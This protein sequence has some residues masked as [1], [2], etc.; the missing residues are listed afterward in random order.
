[1]Q[2]ESEMELKF[3]SLISDVA[4]LRKDIHNTNNTY[5]VQLKYFLNQI[6]QHT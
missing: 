1:M 3:E 6:G 2:T 4:E 5:I